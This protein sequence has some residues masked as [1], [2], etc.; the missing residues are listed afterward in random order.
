MRIIIKLILCLIICVGS[1]SCS[2]ESSDVTFTNIFGFDDLKSAK[3]KLGQYANLGVRTEG[4]LTLEVLTHEAVSSEQVSYFAKVE[5]NG[6]RTNGG[7]YTINNEIVLN[8][9]EDRGSYWIEEYG[10]DLNRIKNDRIIHNLF[11]RQNRVLLENDEELKFDL[12]FET[13][14]LITSEIT[15]AQYEDEKDIHARINKYNNI[16]LSWNKDLEN[17]S[18]ILAYFNWDGTRIHSDGTII[19]DG[20]IVEKAVVLDDL[21]SGNIAS[22]ALSDFPVGALVQLTVLRGKVE[23]ETISEDGNNFRISTMSS[24]IH[25]VIIVD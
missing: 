6:E 13:P 8:Y 5:Q 12:Q 17:E 24:S 1:I 25:S 11:D 16:A 18:G 10:L 14:R 20:T 9:N 7:T 22:E 23:M 3:E 2:E 21:G 4:A 15:S 19:S